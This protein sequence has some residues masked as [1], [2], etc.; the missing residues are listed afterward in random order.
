MREIYVSTTSFKPRDL[1]TIIELCDAAGI[2]A[3]ELSSVDGYSR[4]LLEQHPRHWLVHNYFPPPRDPFVL[5]LASSD[6]EILERSRAHCR[7]ALDL[8]CELD[9]AVYAAHAGYRSDVA[10]A[11][12]GRPSHQA[13]LDATT[14]D[15]YE[16][17]YTTLVESAIELTEYAAARDVHFLIENHVLVSGAGEAGRDLLLMVE[18][19]ELIRLCGDVSHPSFGVLL[20]V[21]HFNVSAAALGFEPSAAIERLAEHIRAFHLSANDG[22]A[23]QHRPFDRDAWFLPW[24]RE[25]RKAAVTVELAEC[26]VAEIL[27]ARDAVAHWL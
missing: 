6:A 10:P 14:F 3:V 7:A 21:G 5:N 15:E 24:V 17:A 2:D 4:N 22:T 1:R 18:V 11:L 8:S 9:S 16:L 19:D 27:A 25:I 20:D 26:E 13:Q 23:D 12:L